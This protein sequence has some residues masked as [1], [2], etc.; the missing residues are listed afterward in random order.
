MRLDP[1]NLYDYEARAKQVLPHNEW[2]AIDA[3][4][5]DEFTTRRNRTAFEALTLR[6]RFLRDVG[7]RDISTTVLGEEISLPVMVAPAGGHTRAH[8]D[9]ELATARGAGM[10]NTLMQLSTSSSY[11]LEE[12][13][14]AATGPLWFQLYH[15]GYDLTEML[16]HRAEEAGFKAVCL[17]VDTPATSPKER[18]LRNRYLRGYEQG[19]FRGMDLPPSVL[20]G[21]D[22][23]PGWDVS[24]VPV[25]TWQE[26]EWLRSLTSLP[27]VL[28]GIRTAEDAHIAVESGVDG[29]QV[30]THGGRQLDMTLGA[31]EMVPEIVDAV[32]GRAEVYVDSGVRRGSDVVKALALG[33]RAVAVG[34]PLFWGLAVNGADGV[35]GML[36]LLREEVSRA[37]AYCG[38]TAVRDLEPN[39][40]NIPPDWGPRKAAP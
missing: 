13:S 29:M 5:M 24:Q 7:Q 33:A 3:G 35:H 25:L 16:V 37:M 30:S 17:T 21:T 8:P 9:G 6:P 15:R 19:N 10:S 12:V 28:K 4:A 20:G 14:E 2:D 18:D 32:K 40:L 11:S 38:Q 34:R 22:E 27:L 36:E 23:T 31:I 39:L 1:I 26:L